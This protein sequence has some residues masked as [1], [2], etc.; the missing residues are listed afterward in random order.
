MA[1]PSEKAGRYEFRVWGKH[2]RARRVLARLADEVTTQHVDDCY[3]LAEPG[4][5]VKVRDR[6]LKVKRLVERSRGFERWAASRYRQPDTAPPPYDQVFEHLRR[7][8]ERRGRAF[9]VAEALAELDGDLAA[10]AVPVTKHRTRYRIG[11]L[12]AEVTDITV[13][14]T[15]EVLRT[16]AIEGHDLDEL[17]ALRRRLGLEETANVAVHLALFPED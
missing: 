7:E 11:E 15:G 8:R 9:D 10:R 12:R 17:E 5:N 6:M 2:A 4:V 1:Q 14:R 3:F 16:L 13:E